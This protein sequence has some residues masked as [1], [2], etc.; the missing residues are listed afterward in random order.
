MAA[1]VDLVRKHI[2]RTAGRA[3]AELLERFVSALFDKADDA[4]FD[5]FDS[6]SLYAMAV[7]GFAF[8]KAL[9]NEDM[10]VEVL[11]PVFEADGWESHYTVVRLVMTDRPFI[12]DSV[13]AEIARQGLELAYQLHPILD[14]VRDENGEVVDLGAETGGRAEAFEMFFVERVEGAE[15]RLLQSRL[16]HVL[17]DVYRATRDY[18]AMLEQSA[19]AAEYLLSLSQA[20]TKPDASITVD[21]V[22]SDLS[23]ELDEYAAFVQWLEDENYV[24]LGYREYQL[25]ELDGETNLQVVEGSGLGILADES[26]SGYRDPVPLSQLSPQLRERVTGGRL[27]VVTK[28][29]AEATVHRA[30]RMDYVGVKV[31]GDKGQVIGERR[32]LGLFTGKAQNTPVEAIPILRRKLRQVL[33]LDEAVPGGHDYKAIVAAFNSLPREEL[34]GTDP[35]QLHKDIRAIL[36]LEQE[37]G[38]K[39]RLRADPLKRGILAMVVMPRESFNSDVRRS[40]QDFLQERLQATSC[41]YRLALSEDQDHARFH[42]YFP[43][44]VDMSAVDVKELESAVT[45]LARSW[46]DDVRA[47]LI[48]AHGDVEG[49]ALAK[50][51]VGA[52]DEGYEAEVS[53]AQAVRDIA[54]LESL[55]MG[56][57]GFDL[58]NKVDDHEASVLVYYPSGRSRALSDVLPILENL[59]LR[60]LDQNPYDLV[61][62]GEPRGV[63][64]YRVQDRA[65]KQL[66]VRQ[67]K[68]RLLEALL[69]LAAGSAESDSLNQLVLYA[70][71]SVRQVS[72]LRAYQM[73]YSQLNLVTS[74][75]FVTSTL[76]SH[77]D[78]AGLLVRYF[79]MR[80]DPKLAGD[81]GEPLAP[82]QREPAL[83]GARDEVLSALSSVATL[84]A[85]Q[86]LRGLLDLMAATVRTNYFLGHPRISFKIDSHQVGSMPQPRPMYEIGVHSPTVEGTHLR[87]GKVARGGIR[88]SDRPDDFRT[89]VLGLMKTQM[90]KNAVIVP[91]GSKGGFV[92]KRAP[93]DQAKLREHVRS[94]YQEYIR[95]L[96]DVTDNIVDGETV[97]PEGVLVYDDDDP[98]LVVAADKGTATFSDVANATAAEY[99]FW[100]G[101]AF[102]SGGSAGYDH[103]GMGIT[104]RGAWEV[105]KRHFAEMGVNVFADEFTVAGIG[106]M[107]GDVFGNGMLYTDKIRLVAA[108][109]H[110]HVFI[111][112]N[113]DA[114]RSFEERKRLFELPRSS[115]ADYDTSLISAGGGVFERGAKS[116][117]ISPEMK[118]LLGIEADQLSG[119]DLIR[120][121]LSAPVDLLWNGGIGTYVKSS[122][123]RHA[124]VGD[125]ANDAVRV[126]A[127]DLRAKVVGEGGNLGFTQL[128]RIEY[129]RAGGR[130]DTDAIHNSAGVDTSDHEV[131]IKICLAPLLRSGAISRAQRDELLVQMQDDVARLVLR[132]NDSQSLAISLALRSS[133]SDPELFG[134]LLDYLVESAGLDR[135]VEFLPTPRQ[136]A[137]RRSEGVSFTRPEL[138]VMLAYVKMGLYRRLLE[139][140]L[141]DDPQLSHYLMEYFPTL[142]RERHPEAIGAHSL[143]REITA[144][145]LTN[146]VVD[147]LGMEFVHRAVRQNGATP[148]EVVRAAL[149]AMELLGTL[150]FADALQER[151]DVTP[152]EASYAAHRAMSQAVEG[153][154]SW[155]LSGDLAKR[156]IKDVV[157]IYGSPVAT[158]QGELERFLPA[159]E[160]RR[161]RASVKQH[162]K[163]GL[164]ERM[165]ERVAG[166]EYVPAGMGVVEAARA[167]EVDMEVAATAFFALGERLALGR[168]RDALRQLP[169]SGSWEK[170]AQTGIVLDLRSAQQRLTTAYLRAAAE[171]PKLSVETFLARQ[172]F[173]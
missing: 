112:P 96:L 34:F 111:D 54:N 27:M 170:I 109:D 128:A 22:T 33:E 137:E 32:F 40:I 90:T 122:T 20:G 84:A 114:K 131:N 11:N 60:V 152:P 102:A 167:A 133:A 25:V 153:V 36:S 166:L 14:V 168:L 118:E 110:R 130:I 28:T 121:V 51:Y 12:V 17:T 23:E 98:Y 46:R 157:A 172:P 78:V 113:P 171:E 30:R 135:A 161:F 3:D 48:E 43:T 93:A 116:V 57:V 97:H 49:R 132:D 82:A 164:E 126:D 86:A 67:D 87:G 124:E 129:A 77:P 104:A 142:L 79:E 65:G 50:R 15:A 74:P 91:V 1:T 88:W 151:D 119:Q 8:L 159:A 80:F 101:D 127:D 38:A 117:P 53:P 66:D 108:F 70:G 107:S 163:G 75:A 62:D 95:G 19:R 147:L 173:L 26:D 61:V 146:V 72:L 125:S 16:K 4:F 63:D 148:V 120:A 42:F 150:E 35:E 89:E 169:T 18:K 100:L 52:F 45:E 69:A 162:V 149:T 64:V 155:L 9:G 71:L 6:D 141:P 55:G 58:I 59:G 81:S 44:E 144:T 103:K 85:D 7:D 68:A 165:A 123:E 41:D 106:D 158:L 140:S 105:V 2:E 13:Q 154:V 83:R 139:T 138:A 10:K 73:Y 160:K 143:R 99:D 134:S 37:R 29:N 76:L 56:A 115:W 145:Q 92:V 156:P 31:L 24:Y 47:R 94:Q 136:L 5:Q 39:L 21:E